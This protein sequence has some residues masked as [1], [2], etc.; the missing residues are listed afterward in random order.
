MVDTTKSAVRYVAPKSS[1]ANNQTETAN[2]DWHVKPRRFRTRFVV[3]V[4]LA[5]AIVFGPTTAALAHQGEQSYLYLDFGDSLVA[6]MQMPFEDVAEALGAEIAG[7]DA[8]I[9]EAIDRHTEQL[10]RYARDHFDIGSETALFAKT[11]TGIGRFADTDYVEVAFKIETDGAIPETLVVDLDPFF[12]SIPDRDALLLIANDWE[13]GVVDNEGEHLLRFTP[14]VRTQTFRLGESSSWQNFTSSISA[15]LDHIRT[16]PDHILFILALLLPSV[17]AWTSKWEPA[18]G[19]G[20]SMW[21]VTK[22]MTMFTLAHSVTFSLAGIGLL[23]TP[24]SQLTEAI[25]ALSIAATAI[26]NLRPV[27]RDREWIIALVFGLFHGFGFASLVQALDVGVQ[28]QLVSLAGRNIGIEIGQLV[29][30]LFVFPALFLLRRTT[31]YLPLLRLACIALI[32][33]SIGWMAERLFDAPTVTS[34]VIDQV[35]KFPRVLIGVAVA[36]IAA[37]V[38]YRR[39]RAAGRLIDIA[40]AQ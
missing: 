5:L 27:F 26:H 22:T 38:L 6:R 20:S 12:D 39:E 37:G 4:L 31:W 15:G 29:V 21:R 16:G 40:G 30:V 2:R 10:R 11:Y 19:F 25:I 13:R 23:P 7:S 14:D 35:L 17:L 36:S 18:R 32:I 9:A 1:S 34:L 24:P 3:L 28:T 33:A 8:E